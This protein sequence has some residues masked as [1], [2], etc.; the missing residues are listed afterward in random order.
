MREA[1]ALRRQR[2]NYDWEEAYRILNEGYDEP[3]KFSPMPK[4]AIDAKAL[5]AW[6]MSPVKATRRCGEPPEDAT[7]FVDRDR[8]ERSPAQGQG[9][10][11]CNGARVPRRSSMAEE[12]SAAR[13]VDEARMRVL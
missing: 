2:F 5:P 13:E 12:L 6:R 3:I 4:I 9:A 10:N 11:E 7:A 1:N 8:G